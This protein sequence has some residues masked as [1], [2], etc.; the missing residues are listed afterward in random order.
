LRQ[1][2]GEQI[3]CRQVDGHTKV[4][5]SVEPSAAVSNRNGEHLIGELRMSPDC[6]AT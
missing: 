3:V 2:F 1:P 5:A 4:V 6:S